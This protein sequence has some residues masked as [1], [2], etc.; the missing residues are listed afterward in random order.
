M[1]RPSSP[2]PWHKSP[3]GGWWVWPPMRLEFNLQS[4][5]SVLGISDPEATNPDQ[6]FVSTKQFS[7]LW[8]CA[9]L[10]VRNNILVWICSF[11]TWNAQHWPFLKIWTTAPVCQSRV[12]VP[13]HHAMLKRRVN[14]NS[15]TIPRAFWNSN[16]YDTMN[17]S[18]VCILPF[19]PFQLNGA[20][21]HLLCADLSLIWMWNSRM[22][23]SIK[24]NNQ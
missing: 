14:W 22:S 3:Q 1:D 2:V 21:F 4:P 7:T 13:N 15:P 20:G 11:G 9:H 19:H 5:S 17:Y 23:F 8:L 12:T 6:Y 18:R 24:E 10:V 16:I